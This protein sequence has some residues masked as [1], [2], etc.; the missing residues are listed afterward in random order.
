[1]RML[2]ETELVIRQPWRLRLIDEVAEAL[3]KITPVADKMAMEVMGK[4]LLDELRYVED[5]QQISADCEAYLAKIPSFL[6]DELM[7]TPPSKL[8]SFQ[9]LCGK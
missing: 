8:V 6:H 3:D 4:G 9:A 2:Y 1:M 7:A 5:V